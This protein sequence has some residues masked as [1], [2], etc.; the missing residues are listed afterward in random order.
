MKNLEIFTESKMNN[1]LCK[2]FLT[3]HHS[4]RRK[5][6]GESRRRG[7]DP[8][9]NNNELR[10]LSMDDNNFFKSINKTIKK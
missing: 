3:S 7:I 10:Q 6:A 2:R 8:V 4:Q 9:D 1:D 5:S